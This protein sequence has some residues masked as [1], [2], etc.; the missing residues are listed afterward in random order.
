M[1]P[2]LQILNQFNPDTI[3][4]G[5][6]GPGTPVSDLGW[7]FL[8]F[9]AVIATYG[10]IQS[11]R[12]A[13]DGDDRLDALVRMFVVVAF[14]FFGPWFVSGSR[15][16]WSAVQDHYGCRPAQVSSRCLMLALRSPE[17]DGIINANVDAIANRR[18]SGT[19]TQ[20]QAQID[21]QRAQEYSAIG[22]S[23]ISAGGGAIGRSFAFLQGLY[24]RARNAVPDF[25]SIITIATKLMSMLLA[26]ALKLVLTLVL[27][28]F[29]DV[30]MTGI[31]IVSIFMELLQ[32]FLIIMMN[33]MLP[34]FVGCFALPSSHPFR[35]TARNYC[36]NLLATTMWP[37]AW[38]IGHTGTKLIFNAVVSAP[39]TAALVGPT[40][41]LDY[42][43]ILQSPLQGAT[44]L[45][46]AQQAAT[47]GLVVG[48]LLALIGVVILVVW[49]FYVTV[50]L[51]WT[52]RDL[53]ISG[54]DMIGQVASQAA[55]GAIQQMAGA[56]GAAGKEMQMA[57]IA[58]A[59]GGAG[60]AAGVAAGAAGGAAGGAGMG[61]VGGVGGVLAGVGGLFSGGGSG[62]VSGLG[63]GRMAQG[64]VELGTQKDTRAALQSIA[65]NLANQGK[66]GP[67]PT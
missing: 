25:F 52:L 22:S 9:G 32:L 13:K 48:L 63:W 43:N 21:A 66:P 34:M 41:N 58:A 60:L 11:F 2:I 53:L 44:A 18:V 39:T 16:F 14:M 1:N 10:T 46:H 4:H 3:F 49:T 47:S 51:P 35:S 26:G 27:F 12:S 20:T 62:V 37:L 31:A 67:R 42:G 6:S 29:M 65:Q 5:I 28:L 64:S 23:L 30:L 17:L 54:A 33:M 7:L 59:T 55:G 40:R 36:L 57:A 8:L 15:S 24:D 19:G 50:K 56:A 38:T 61:A 45:I